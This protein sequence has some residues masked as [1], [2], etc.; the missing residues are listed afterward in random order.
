MGWILNYFLILAFK[1]VPLPHLASG[2]MQQYIRVE[3]YEQVG[4]IQTSD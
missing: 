3:K 1:I 4:A 2:K